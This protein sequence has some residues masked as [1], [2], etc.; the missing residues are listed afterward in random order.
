MEWP[1]RNLRERESSVHIGRNFLFFRLPRARQRHLGIAD[2]HAR[3]VNHPTCNASGRLRE[4]FL[5]AG[6]G[7]GNSWNR[8]R[9]L[10]E[11]YETTK[12]SKASQPPKTCGVEQQT[13][14]HKT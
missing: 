8:L 6:R 13:L 4:H 9:S 11:S 14:L 12:Q 10:R 5:V 3:L 7:T 2:V 1:R